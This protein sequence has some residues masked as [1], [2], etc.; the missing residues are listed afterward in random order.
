[1]NEPSQVRQR[2]G[3]LSY[4]KSKMEKEP[5]KNNVFALVDEL[6]DR[7]KTDIIYHKIFPG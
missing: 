5:T 3:R 7:K 2:D 4:L 6:Q 1:M